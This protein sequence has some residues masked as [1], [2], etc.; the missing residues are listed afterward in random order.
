MH[1]HYFFL[2]LLPLLISFAVGG[3]LGLLGGNAYVLILWAF[4][5]LFIGTFSVSIKGGLA[6]GAAYGF[7]LAYCFM[8]SGYD[9][10]QPLSS[11]LLPFVIF[12]VFGSVCGIVLGLIGYGIARRASITTF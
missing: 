4:V 6:N 9:G 7:A 3:L 2:S 12:G 1:K 8:I 11:R 5:G 10:S